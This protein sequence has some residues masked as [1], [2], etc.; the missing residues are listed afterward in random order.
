MMDAMARREHDRWVAERLLAG[1]R[2]AAAGE[3]RDNDLMIHDK[4]IGWDGLT[5]ADRGND[6]VQVRAAFDIARVMNPQGFV[7]R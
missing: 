5:E 2:P 4:L 1:W 3:K 7:R 6:V